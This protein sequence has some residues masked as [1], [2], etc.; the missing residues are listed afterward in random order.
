MPEDLI[1]KKKAY[2][3]VDEVNDQ[4]MKQQLLTG[5]E[6]ALNEGRL[7]P[8]L[9]SRICEGES[10]STSE[11]VGVKGRSPY[12]NTLNSDQTPRDWNTSIFAV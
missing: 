5:G 2:T 8:D 10:R 1:Q 4:D 6:R 9:E 3:F 11:A 7:G 12:K